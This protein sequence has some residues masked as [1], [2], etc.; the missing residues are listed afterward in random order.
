M[1]NKFVAPCTKSYGCSS[2]ELALYSTDGKIDYVE[3]GSCGLIWRDMLSC[4]DERV[5][6]GAYFGGKRYTDKWQHRINKAHRLL[7]ILETHVSPGRFLEIGPALGYNLEAAVQ[8]GWDVQ[9]VDV[10]SFAVEGCRDR[11]FDVKE[12]DLFSLGKSDGPYNAILFKHVLEH[13]RNP[14]DALDYSR[15][16]LAEEGCLE[17]IVPNA[18]YSRA[19]KMRGKSKFYCHERGG[20]D[21]FVYF[22]RKTLRNILEH[23][24][25]SIVQEGFPMFVGG[26][27]S[28]GAVMDRSFRRVMA[29]VNLDQELLVIAKKNK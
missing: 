5:Y 3:C 19:K 15:E 28:L 21:H 17:I 25:F 20:I 26:D 10:S 14:F 24:G 2:D 8:R 9:G 16:L 6:D 23:T 18:E 7:A 13:Y 11:G 12:G 27:N 4:D 22:D 29:T 1:A